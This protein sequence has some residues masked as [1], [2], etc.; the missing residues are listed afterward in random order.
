MWDIEVHHGAPATT[1][2]VLFAVRRR[3]QEL[4]G[5]AADSVCQCA[6]ECHLV[7]FQGPSECLASR[8]VPVDVAASG[9][10]PVPGIASKSQSATSDSDV[11][12]LYI[13]VSAVA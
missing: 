5:V 11:E 10:D 7:Q 12:V 13:Y 6:T 1:E 3:P 9:A 8:P 4:V 2:L